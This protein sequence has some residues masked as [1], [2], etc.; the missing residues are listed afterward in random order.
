[1]P[2]EKQDKP[3]AAAPAN[4]DT[5]SLTDQQE[6]AIELW[7]TLEHKDLIAAA[8]GVTPE[9]LQDWQ[10]QPLFRLALINEECR[11]DADMTELQAAA[12]I[13][14]KASF[15]DAEKA[16]K[17]DPGTITEWAKEYGSTFTL[18]LEAMTEEAHEDDRTERHAKHEAEKEALKEQQMLAIPHIVAGKTDAEVAEIVG[19]S[20]ETINRWRNHDSEFQTELRQSRQA[21]LD[22]HLMTVS[23]VNKK[24]VNVLEELLDSEDE[25]VRL[26]AAMHLLKTVPLTHKEPKS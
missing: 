14:D 18:L 7:E 24:A 17:L 23:N 1:M 4:P 2:K 26:R 12:L 11:H 9:V 8:V 22:A 16:L 6:Q 10:K 21:Q 3:I 25:Q 13:M 5:F 19:V 20:R 15:A